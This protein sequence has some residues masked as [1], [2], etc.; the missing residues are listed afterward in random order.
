M[1]LEKIGQKLISVIEI[2]KL[3]DIL[4]EDN[5]NFRQGWY[6]VSY[7]NLTGYVFGDY[8][9]IPQQ[10]KIYTPSNSTAIKGIDL[11]YHQNNIDWQKVKNSGV[12]FVIIRGGY[13]TIED[14]NFKTHMEGALN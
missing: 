1:W 11:S 14:K 7:K 10:E 13:S 3:G 5:D 12:K 4:K 6:K 9:K 2:N 8:I